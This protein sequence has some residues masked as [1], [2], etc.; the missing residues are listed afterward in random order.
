LLQS[1]IRQKMADVGH[2]VLIWAALYLQD[3]K[4]EGRSP[5]LAE[6]WMLLKIRYLRGICK[7]VRLTSSETGTNKGIF[8]V[9]SCDIVEKSQVWGCLGRGWKRGLHLFGGM[10]IGFR[11]NA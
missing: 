3:I 2:P 1:H 7:I 9:Q 5:H 10:I 8:G 6:N 11:A 4:L